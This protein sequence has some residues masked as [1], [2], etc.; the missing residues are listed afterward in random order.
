M[1]IF[2]YPTLDSG[3]TLNKHDNQQKPQRFGGSTRY[4]FR[5]LLD[6]LDLIL[7]K[8]VWNFFFE[9]VCSFL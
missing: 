5:E 3:I 8:I 6:I 4:I 7:N 1:G 2:P 9:N